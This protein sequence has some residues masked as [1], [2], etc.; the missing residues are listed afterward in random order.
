LVIGDG[1]MKKEQREKIGKWCF[2]HC[3]SKEYSW[4]S[5]V[6]MNHLTDG[7]IYNSPKAVTIRHY[8]EIIDDMHKA[9]IFH[10][11][12]VI[13]EHKPLRDFEKRMMT[14]MIDCF[15]TEEMKEDIPPGEFCRE[16][17]AAANT[18]IAVTVQAACAWASEEDSSAD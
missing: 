18:W 16:I 8:P 17:C 14:G 2:N 3:E 13:N 10:L 11:S 9:L 12:D 6:I 4:V 1:K 5:R 7:L 15:C